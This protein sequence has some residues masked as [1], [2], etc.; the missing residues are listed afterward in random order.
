[1]NEHTIL[2]LAKGS[3][4]ACMNPEQA[5]FLNGSFINSFDIAI[6]KLGTE[7]IPVLLLYSYLLMT[8]QM[9]CCALRIKEIC[10]LLSSVDVCKSNGNDDISALQL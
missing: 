5:N 9:R 10:G 3:V 8:V 2:T 7:D 4:V 6:P 1:M